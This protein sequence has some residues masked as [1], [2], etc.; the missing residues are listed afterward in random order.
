M[1]QSIRAGAVSERDS[2]VFFVLCPHARD[3]TR[4]ILCISENKPVWF[5]IATLR[6]CYNVGFL[7]EM[8]RTIKNCVVPEGNPRTTRRRARAR[9]FIVRHSPLLS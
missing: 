6:L 9:A 7:R 8:E 5:S 3:A 4:G 2:A 1:V